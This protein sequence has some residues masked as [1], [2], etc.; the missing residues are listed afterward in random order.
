MVGYV[1]QEVFLFNSSIRENLLWS[2]S[3]IVDEEIWQILELVQLANLVKGLPQQLNSLVGERGANL[4]GG[5]RQRLLL[6]RTLLRKPQL[7]IL[8]EAT[9]ALDE[10]NQQC[11]KTIL[12][13]LK[14]QLII[15]IITHHPQFLSNVDRI[16]TIKNG[17]LEN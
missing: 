5:E 17:V 8:D 1:T 14:G 13:R 4:S 15:L 12:T 7:L 11:I 10:E 16:I 6:A 3:D 9:S 2:N